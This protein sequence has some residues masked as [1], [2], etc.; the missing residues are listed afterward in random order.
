MILY[1]SI[2]KEIDKNLSYQISCLVCNEL[3]TKAKL[4]VHNHLKKH[5]KNNEITLDQRNQIMNKML[6]R[7][8]R[9]I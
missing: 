9:Q 4:S 6:K 1:K 5:F 8:V 3:V 2:S 7:Y